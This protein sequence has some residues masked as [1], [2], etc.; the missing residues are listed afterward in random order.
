MTI[1]VGNN[2]GSDPTKIAFNRRLTSLKGSESV[3]TATLLMASII[4]RC[5]GDSAQP[6][7]RTGSCQ[8]D[9][10]TRRVQNLAEERRKLV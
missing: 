1:A 2:L 10:G 4:L 6:N 8:D 3:P 5:E 9:E 7:F